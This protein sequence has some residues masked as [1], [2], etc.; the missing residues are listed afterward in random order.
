VALCDALV[1]LSAEAFPVV[2]TFTSWNARHFTGKTRLTALTPRE[3]LE[4]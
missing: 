3:F 2:D 1:L 4:Q